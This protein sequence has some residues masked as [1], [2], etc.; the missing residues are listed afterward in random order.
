MDTSLIGSIVGCTCCCLFWVF[1]I[2]LIAG[3]M[4]LRKKGKK[5]TAKEAVTEGVEQ[6]SRV[7]VRGNKTREEMLREDDENNR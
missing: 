2:V 1:V 6:V 7:F 5:V 4:A 3:V